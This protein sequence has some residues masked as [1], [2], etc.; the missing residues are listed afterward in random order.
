MPKKKVF[1]R[2]Y[3]NTP[4]WQSTELGRIG[5]FKIT[6]TSFITVW[7][8][9]FCGYASVVVVQKNEGW[10]IGSEERKPM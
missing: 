7:R 8:M 2:I 4:K 9:C 1:S 6:G 5:I 3:E 10:R